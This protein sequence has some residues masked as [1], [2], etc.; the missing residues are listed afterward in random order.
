[1]IRALHRLTLLAFLVVPAFGQELALLAGGLRSEE[2]GDLTYAW[3][4]AYRHPLRPKLGV[5]FAWTNEGHLPHHHRDGCSIQLWYCLAGWDSDFS[6]AAGL[7]PYRYYDTR[8]GLEASYRNQHGVGAMASLQ[9]LYSP[10]GSRWSLLGQAFTVRIQGSVDTVGLQFGLSHRFG[11][12]VASARQAPPRSGVIPR[13]HLGIFAGRTILNSLSSEAA[14][15]WGIEYRR[16]FSSHWALG[17]AYANEGDPVL[18]R[19]DGLS[20]QAWLGGSPAAGPIYLGVGVGPHLA[21]I[22]LRE[23]SG[24]AVDDF[25]RIGLRVSMGIGYCVAPDWMIR[26]NWHRTFSSYDRDTDMFVAGIGYLW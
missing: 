18:M 25:N 11:K 2:A 26:A 14:E 16:A 19:R 9:G 10:K 22:S 12:S 4:V 24:G 13:N 6:L 8:P 15:A 1:M 17:V 20:L 5:S 7:G 3:Q 23:S 21:R